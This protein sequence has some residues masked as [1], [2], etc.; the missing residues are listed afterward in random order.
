MGKI[1]KPFQGVSNIVR[2][3]WHF[4]AVSLGGLFVLAILYNF[5]NESFRFVSIVLFCGII[6]INLVT[7]AVSFYV[8]DLSN[9]YGLDW[10]DD[11]SIAENS[12]IVNVNAGFDETS[13]L[14]QDKFKNSRLVVFDF[15]DRT[16]HTEISIERA[17][18]AYPPYPNT[19][20]V[21]TDNLPL[22]NDFADCV[23]AVLS[24]HEIRNDDERKLFFA[25]TRRVLKP[26][27][28]IIV[29]EHLR[30]IANFMAYNIGF[31]HFHS[32]KTWL[33]TFAAAGLKV[34]KEIKITPFITTF[35]LEKNGVS[36]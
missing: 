3:N 11:L 34:R 7:L 24:A 16:K 28:Q 2:F 4:Y 32:R 23:F 29:V 21:A 26:E 13:E 25:E 36:S 10:L 35:V 30:D 17:R 33:E 31:F 19:E 18:K 27:G 5:L 1:R 8:Y 6:L 20:Q 9:L 12:E 14:L 22:A 15:Y